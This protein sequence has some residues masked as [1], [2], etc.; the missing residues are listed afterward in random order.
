MSI[1]PSP[2]PLVAENLVGHGGGPH[3]FESGVRWSLWAQE[4]R[5][6]AQRIPGTPDCTG[7]PLSL[8]STIHYCWML[9]RPEHLR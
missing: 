7:Q 5:S 9:D 2:V 1:E 4:L 8:M 6:N 3:Q